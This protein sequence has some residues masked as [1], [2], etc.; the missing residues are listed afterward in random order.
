[1][2]VFRYQ[3]LKAR[4]EAIPAMQTHAQVQAKT[5]LNLAGAPFTVI[6]PAVS[7]AVGVACLARCTL[8]R[9]QMQL[10]ATQGHAVGCSGPSALGAP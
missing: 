4:D 7:V 2:I 6:C 1:M 9:P 10:G 5:R 3:A 8:R